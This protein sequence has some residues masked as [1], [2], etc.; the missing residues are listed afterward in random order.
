FDIAAFADKMMMV[1][2][3]NLVRILNF[4]KSLSLSNINFSAAAYYIG[5]VIF[6]IVE[7]II[8]IIFTGGSATVAKLFK[9]GAD[10]M[11]KAVKTAMSIADDLLGM[12]RYLMRLFEKGVDEVVAFFKKI[13][14]DFFDWL[15]DMFKKGKADEVLEE[16]SPRKK[17]FMQWS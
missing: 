7:I 5:Y 1:Y 10:V 16:L 6:G 4:V 17:A 14:D 2:T 8:G 15:E 12:L 13:T 3:V 9:T 11:N